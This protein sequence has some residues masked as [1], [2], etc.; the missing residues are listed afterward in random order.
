MLCTLTSSHLNHDRQK[1]WYSS[2]VTRTLE[3]EMLLSCSLSWHIFILFLWFNVMFSAITLP[4]SFLTSAAF[5]TSTQICF[6]IALSACI[7]LG[8]AEWHMRY[9]DGQDEVCCSS[10]KVYGESSY[11]KMCESIQRH[12]SSFNWETW[13]YSVS[14]LK[15]QYG[16]TYSLGFY[17]LKQRLRSIWSGVH[18]YAQE[19]VN[20]PCTHSAGGRIYSSASCS[21]ACPGM[22][23]WNHSSAQEKAPFGRQFLQL[24]FVKLPTP[25]NG[26]ICVQ[27]H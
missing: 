4:S 15:A 18:S 1:E 25:W 11:G 12:L 5:L 6:P 27:V 3:R 13:V 2:V 21:T 10:L 22:C 26:L 17:K 7:V 20:F 16:P 9:P 23:P 8:Q 24:G 19:E 14:Q